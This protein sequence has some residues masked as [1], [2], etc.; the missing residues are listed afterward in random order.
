METVSQN[1]QHIFQLKNDYQGEVVATL[2]IKKDEVASAKAI[3]YLHGFVDY[4]FQEELADWANSAGFNFYALDLRK[5][6]RSILPHQSPNH[7]RK[8][9]EFFEEID[10]AVHFIWN[11]EKNDKLI[12]MGHSTGGLI[13][14]LYTDQVKDKGLIDALILNSPFFDFNVGNFKKILLPLFSIFGSLTPELNTPER[15]ASG[16]GKSVHKNFFGEWNYDLKLKPIDGFP[17]KF[18]WLRAIFQAQNE[19]KKGLHI[20]CPVLVMHS[21]KSVKPGKYNPSMQEADAVLNV[22]DIKKY[23]GKLGN[24]VRTIEI[25]NGM[26]DLILSKAAVRAIVYLEMEA[27]IRNVV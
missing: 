22:E 9:T 23:A 18:G 12:L 1:Y 13:A 16:Y 25:E 19:V 5:H 2:S 11:I 8:H 15:L 24:N 6:G 21:S 10:L 17:I 27:F 7:F 20:Q 4:F 14:S 26:H 3:L